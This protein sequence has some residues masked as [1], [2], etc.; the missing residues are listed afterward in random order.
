[1]SV[2]LFML[3]YWADKTSHEIMIL[4]RINL[5]CLYLNSIA[6]LESKKTEDRFNQKGKVMKQIKE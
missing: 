6:K 3:S 4:H 1:M 2:L 5:N